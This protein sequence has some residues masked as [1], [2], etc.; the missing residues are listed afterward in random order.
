MWISSLSHT[1]HWRD[2]LFHMC[3]LSTVVKDELTIY[4]CMGWFLRSLSSSIDLHVPVRISDK[5]GE[6]ELKLAQT[7]FWSLSY[8]WTTS[9][10]KWVFY[11]QLVFPLLEIH[12]FVEF[13]SNIVLNIIHETVAGLYTSWDLAISKT[14]TKCKHPWAGKALCHC[15]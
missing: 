9:L 5:C 8:T 11:T 4:I 12:Y 2:H 6:S 15:Q 13:S 3:V 14:L 7:Q 10:S 1:V